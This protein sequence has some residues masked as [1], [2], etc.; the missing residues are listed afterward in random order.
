MRGVRAVLL[1]CLLSACS[2]G[3]SQSASAVAAAA[4]NLGP[5]NNQFP[6]D[7]AVCPST[8]ESA[9]GSACDVEGLICYPQYPCGIA[10]G[11]ATCTCT[12]GHFAC[13]DQLGA[14]LHPDGGAPGCPATLATPTCPATMTLANLTA[15]SQAGQ[16]CTYAS[17]CTSIPAYLD[18]QC[19][20]LAQIDG[21]DYLGYHCDD[22]CTPGNAPIDAGGATTPP[23]EAGTTLPVEAGPSTS[24]SH[25]AAADVR[26]EANPSD[27]TAD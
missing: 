9:P 12:A 10:P 25:D 4:G 17:P 18:C 15:C 24:G 5:T 27:A 22:I 6:E 8:V 3:G 13:V 7:Q 21:G 14:S 11:Q 26:S 20:P 16:I 19:V 2:S 1:G 23:V